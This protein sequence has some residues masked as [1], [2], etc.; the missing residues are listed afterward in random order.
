MPVYSGINAGT[1]PFFHRLDVRLERALQMKG[2]KIEMYFEWNNLYA[3]QNVVGYSYDPSY[4]KKT[5]VYP[6]VLP[7]SFGVQAAF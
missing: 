1:L 2:Y 5:P 6:F 3:R 7:I 4:T